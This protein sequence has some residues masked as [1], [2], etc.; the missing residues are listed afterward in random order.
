MRTWAPAFSSKPDQPQHVAN[1]ETARVEAAKECQDLAHLQLLRELR[2]LQLDAEPAAQRQAVASPPI[3]EHLDVTGVGVPE[4]FEDL[5]GRR[6]AGAVRA[7]HAEALA[8]A[9]LEVEPGDGNDIAVFLDQ[10]AAGE[11]QFRVG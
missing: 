1:P 2:L 11:R 5:D 3:A 10:A 6:L 8:G 4:A 9:D 7:E